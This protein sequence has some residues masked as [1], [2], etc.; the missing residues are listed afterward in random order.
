MQQF[1]QRGEGVDA[2][3]P[4]GAWALLF[5]KNCSVSTVVDGG[6]VLKG[7]S[8]TTPMSIMQLYQKCIKSVTLLSSNIVWFFVFF[9]L[10]SQ[11]HFA[12]PRTFLV[13]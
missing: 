1:A 6:S 4:A 8:V 5:F 12:R 2:Y 13:L 10:K 11:K 3:L 9:F 7:P